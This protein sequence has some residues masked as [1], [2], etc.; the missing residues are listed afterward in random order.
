MIIMDIIIGILVL[1]CFIIDDFIC[2]LAEVKKD[3]VNVAKITR[4]SINEEIN[5]NRR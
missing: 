5:Y 3:F 2:F 4:I 1:I